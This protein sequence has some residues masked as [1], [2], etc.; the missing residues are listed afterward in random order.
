M[1]RSLANDLLLITYLELCT[2]SL[3][4]ERSTLLGVRE[5]QH[6]G[7]SNILAHESLVILARDLNRAVRDETAS[8]LLEGLKLETFAEVEVLSRDGE[9]GIDTNSREVGDS[10]LLADIS[11]ILAVAGANSKDSL[12]LRSELLVAALHIARHLLRLVV[13]N[14]GD[15]GIA[16]LAH[17]LFKVKLRVDGDVTHGVIV[18]WH[19]LRASQK[20]RNCPNILH[21]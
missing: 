17:L 20:N 16:V 3:V 7:G 19:G 21:F 1:K 11:V 15:A 9:R 10:L 18:K 8:G 5:Q 13:V 2:E 6:L 4:D 12:V 14:D